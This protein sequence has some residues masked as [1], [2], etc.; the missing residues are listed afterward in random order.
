MTLK[1]LCHVILGCFG[2]IFSCRL[3]KETTTLIYI[4]KTKTRRKKER[5]L[6][7]RIKVDGPFKSSRLFLQIVAV[8]R[9]M[10]LFRFKSYQTAPSLII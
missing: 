4:G 5:K 3:T 7:F 9:G 2:E 8:Y 10:N 6:P 1:G